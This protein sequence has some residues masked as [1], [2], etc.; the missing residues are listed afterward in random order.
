MSVFEQTEEKMLL[1]FSLFTADRRSHH[2]IPLTIVLVNTHFTHVP[3]DT[4][5]AL[6]K[7]LNLE[8]RKTIVSKQN[9]RSLLFTTGFCGT[10]AYLLPPV[11][12]GG[13]MW[14]YWVPE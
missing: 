14:T 2:S 8:N 10:T 4:R 1:F 3:N 13:P 5:T 11:P 6:G 9:E 7:N 12:G